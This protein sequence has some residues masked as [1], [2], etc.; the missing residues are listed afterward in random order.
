MSLPVIDNPDRIEQVP[1]R[2]RQVLAL[3]GGGYRGLFSASVL[4]HCETH[5]RAACA[6]RFDLIAGTS[7][8]A[9][10]AAGLACGKSAGDL[11]DLFHKHGKTIFP[12]SRVRD[13]SR[14]AFRAP[15]AREPV[16]AAI[17]EALGRERADTP[18][19]EIRPRLLITAVNYTTGEPAIFRSGGLDPKASPDVTL[20]QAITAS[21]AAPSFFPVRKIG[22]DDYIDGGLIAN[23]PDMIA[24]GEARRRMATRPENLYMLSVGTAARR[25]GA[26]LADDEMRPSGLSWVK[27]KRLV[28]TIMASQERLALEQVTQLLDA[29]H[30]RLDI[31]PAKEQVASIADLDQADERATATLMSLAGQCWEKS[32][33]DRKLRDFFKD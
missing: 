12:K 4:A 23:A 2:R 15:Y 18:L 31:E 27:N 14:A 25:D 26:A 20:M 11:A 7:I 3:S 24:Y 30:L 13:A 8:S 32:L 29:R 33:S 16:E 28:Q 1:S 5:Y 10:L 6:D 22:S 9:L 19:R 21:A 17:V